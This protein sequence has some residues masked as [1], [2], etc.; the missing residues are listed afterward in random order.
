MWSR[1][2]LARPGRTDYGS[3]RRARGTHTAV[4]CPSRWRHLGAHAIT[5]ALSVIVRGRV[6]V[7]RPWL[8]QETARA[9]RRAWRPETLRE[10]DGLRGAAAVA[11]G[12]GERTF[13][14]PFTSSSRSK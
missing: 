8:Q 10:R 6:M 9:R 1:A 3:P 7:Q 4:P 12:A 11:R 5:T 13:C 2:L 14:L